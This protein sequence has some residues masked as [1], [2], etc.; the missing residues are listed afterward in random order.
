MFKKPIFSLILIAMMGFG[1]AACGKK[2][3][4]SAPSASLPAVSISVLG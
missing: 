2:A 3:P 1:L 4:P